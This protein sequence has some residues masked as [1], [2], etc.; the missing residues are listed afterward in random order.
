MTLRLP[1]EIVVEQFLPTARAMLATALVERG[2]TQREVADRLGVTQA[3]VS[4]YVGGDVPIEERF[5]DDERM[6]TTV[7]HIA[8]GFASGGMDEYEALAELL[9]LV[10]AFEDRG[11]I[12]AAHEAAVPAL[13]GLGCDLCVRGT[14]AQLEAERTVLSNV[15]RALRTIEAEP[16]FVPLVPNVGTNLGM[17]LPD[18]VDAT[19]VAAVPGRVHAMR[20]RVHVPS[21]PEFGASEHVATALLAATAADPEVRGAINLATSEP[22]LE[23]ARTA[24]LSL[25]EF[26]P[27]YETR[28]ERLE[29]RF[30]EDGPVPRICYHRGDFG[31]EPITYVLGESALAAAELATDLAAAAAE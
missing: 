12:C 6:R 9:S 5:A 27:S 21:N 13:E 20:G 16:A 31:V 29:S 26:E 30:R 19:D 14:D 24:G 2:F 15:R 22:F 25:L 17:A 8:D 18:P 4:R 23:A 10:R 1:S 11:P 7:D 28:R 3:Q